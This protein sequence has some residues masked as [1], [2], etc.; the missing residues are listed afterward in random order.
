MG[1]NIG[2][3]MSF[4]GFGAPTAAAPG[5]AGAPIAPVTDDVAMQKMLLSSPEVQAAMLQ[6]GE[7]ALA[8]PGVQEAIAKVAREKGP[9][10]AEYAVGKVQEWAHDPEVQAKAKHYAGMAVGYVGVAAGQAGAAFIGCIEQGPAGIRRLSCIGGLASLVIS[11]LTLINPLRLL[12]FASYAIAAYQAMFSATTMLFEAKPELIA[13]V[14]ILNRYQDVLLI[15]CKFLATN[16]GRGLF[17]IFQGS[18]WIVMCDGVQHW[19][20]F[21]TGLYMGLL[22]GG[23]H[24]AMHYGHMPSELVA[25]AK[26]ITGYEPLPS[27]APA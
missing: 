12:T 9:E 4:F 16:G 3:R 22:M 24:L 7:K 10:A 1:P 15:N 27:A 5:A 21:L 18:L 13:Q 17:Y 2:A 26:Q 25:K 14:S 19:Y 6:A 23:F 11:C 20:M 8:D